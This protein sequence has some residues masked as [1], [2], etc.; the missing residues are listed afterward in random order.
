[1]KSLTSLVE[2]GQCCEKNEPSV[3]NTALSSIRPLHP[4][5]FLSDGLL[6]TIVLGYQKS[7]VA[8]LGIR[9]K[10]LSCLFILGV[11]LNTYLLMM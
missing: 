6:G 10:V 11:H 2:A 1:L 5:F 3:H 4:Q 9:Y 7:T 8:H